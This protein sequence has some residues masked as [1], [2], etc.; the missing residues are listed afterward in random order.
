MKNRERIYI[1]PTRYGFLY[2]MGILVT[3]AAGTIYAN[4]LVYLLSFFLVAL[5]LIGMVQT[6]SNLKGLEVS[7]LELFLS[8]SES[9]G[10]GKIWIQ[11]HSREGHNQLS[12]ESYKDKNSFNFNIPHL[13]SQSLSIENFSYN[14][15]DRGRKKIKKIKLSSKYPFGLFYSWRIYSIEKDYYVYPKPEGN[16]QLPELTIR[17]EAL[18]TKWGQQ[19]DDYTDH[20][21]YVIGESQRHIDWKAYAKGRPLLVKVFNDGE[22]SALEINLKEISGDLESQLKQIVMWIEECESRKI[23]YSLKLEN[24]FIHSS[25]GPQHRDSCFK[26]LA[27]FKSHDVA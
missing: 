15:N 17:G 4:N 12:I 23:V 22:R 25:L 1:I 13:I 6:H 8:P 24:N 2:G 20:K 18:Q 11:S 26:L 10:T 21:K 7:K 19:G 5:V 14:T 16:H 9:L 27:E 3:L